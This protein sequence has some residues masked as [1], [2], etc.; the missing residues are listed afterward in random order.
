MGGGESSDS[1]EK[2]VEVGKSNIGNI[3]RSAVAGMGYR[4]QSNI[5][6]HR[7]NK[8]FGNVLQEFADDA[9][10]SL[11][12]GVLPKFKPPG[13]KTLDS[14]ILVL[15]DIL[16]E[17]FSVMGRINEELDNVNEKP[18]F[19][20]LV[21]SSR[22]SLKAEAEKRVESQRIIQKWQ[23]ELPRAIFDAIAKKVA[24]Y[25]R[26]DKQEIIR[27]IERARPKLFHQSET[28][29]NLRDKKEAAELAF[30]SFMASNDYQSKDGEVRFPTQ[31]ASQQY[32]R[33]SQNIQDNADEME[34][35][36]QQTLSRARER[37]E[38]FGR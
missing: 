2:V 27:A 22:A 16:Q 20:P 13:D 11:D 5:A 35:F 25:N 6:G 28:I 38:K 34:A 15:N 37:A 36:R 21:L 32:L 30:L 23:P 33:L 4:M 7:L 26:S 1:R 31:A 12:T 14:E 19:D 18:V 24:S 10:K 29:C 8:Q 3:A 17:A 9:E